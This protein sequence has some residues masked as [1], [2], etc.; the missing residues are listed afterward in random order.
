V[1]DVTGAAGTVEAVDATGA[2]ETVD[3]A[4]AVA[5]VGAVGVVSPLAAGV[6]DGG[7]ATPEITGVAGT[8][9]AVAGGVVGAVLELPR[10]SPAWRSARN[11]SCRN[12]CRSCPRF[13]VEA[14]EFPVLPAAE[15]AAAFE[16]PLVAVPAALPAVPLDLAA[17]ASV[18]ACSKLE[19]KLPP[20][21]PWPDCAV[22][23][24][25]PDCAVRQSPLLGACVVE[26]LLA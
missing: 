5:T 11:R 19:N 6:V 22:R 23:Q 20:D 25:L 16:V 13:D 3:A 26:P 24:S 17:T 18:S 15:L 10:Q 21:D 12:A 4:G 1:A 2:V 7:V 14:V 8:V 9:T